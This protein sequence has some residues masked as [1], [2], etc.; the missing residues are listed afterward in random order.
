V[1]LGVSACLPRTSHYHF[2]NAFSYR[3]HSSRLTIV[4]DVHH[5]C[6]VQGRSRHWCRHQNDNGFL[7][8]E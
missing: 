2:C 5:G 4:S 3:S 7:H 8:R 6:P 1:N